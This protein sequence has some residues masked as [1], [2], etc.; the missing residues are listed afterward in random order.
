[1]SKRRPC[2]LA[3]RPPLQSLGLALFIQSSPAEPNTQVCREPATLRFDIVSG[4]RFTMMGST[5]A[6][7]ALGGQRG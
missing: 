2:Q 5:R 1:M 4:S 7:D 3:L 6:L